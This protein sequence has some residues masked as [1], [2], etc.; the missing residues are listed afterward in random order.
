[1]APA[2]PVVLVHGLRASRTMWRAQVEALQRAGH[3]ALAID[4]PGHGER[5][6]ETFTWDGALQAVSDGVD[7]IGGPA[8]VVGLS[9]GGY[10]AIAHAARH[11]GQVAGLVA[12]GCSSRPYPV[13]LRGW[14][15]AAD[16]FF[17]R[18]PDRGAAV[19][20]V[21]VDRFLPA[22]GAADAG[23]GGF[24]LDVVGD[25]M[26]AMRRA[27]PL[28]DLARLDVP[29]WIV[30]GRFDHFRGEERRF[31][32]AC[33]EGH[34]V[35]VPG[36]SHLVSLVQPVRFTRVLL[37]VLDE[38]AARADRSGVVRAQVPRAHAPDDPGLVGHDDDVVAEPL[39]RGRRH[40]P[41]V[42]AAEVEPVPVEDGAQPLDDR[43]D[44]S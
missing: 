26:R 6:A 22:Q 15:A 3:P 42:A 31:L 21:L 36:A 30:N 32:A 13:V 28:T 33:R 43:A 17:A 14:E 11:P 19:N 39:E 4:L 18:L 20:Q 1:M 7:E 23:A 29:V 44:P 12:A 24:A 5:I 35:V 2:P 16:R 10:I 25:T 40:A 37:E 38:L 8:L 41:G 27:D 34:L 9:L